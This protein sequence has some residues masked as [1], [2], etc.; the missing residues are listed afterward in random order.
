[1]FGMNVLGYDKYQNPEL[2]FITYVSFDDI[3]KN[4]D[5]ISL[6][7]PL[8]EETYHILQQRCHALYLRRRHRLLPL[9]FPL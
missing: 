6:H 8:M 3:L 4:S 7:C 1:G 2:D 5:L 9:L